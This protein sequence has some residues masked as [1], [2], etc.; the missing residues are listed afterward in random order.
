[1]FGLALALPLKAKSK[2]KGWIHEATF[3]KSQLS[4]IA[5]TDSTSE[6]AFSGF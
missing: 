4:R 6:P 5:K 1:V 2:S 3:S